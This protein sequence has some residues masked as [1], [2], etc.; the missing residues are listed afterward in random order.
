MDQ[1][2]SDAE[3]KMLLSGM[4]EENISVLDA[5]IENCSDCQARLERMIS[6]GNVVDGF[7]FKRT[8]NAPTDWTP[9]RQLRLTRNVRRQVGDAYSLTP[10]LPFSIGDFQFIKEIGRGGMGIVFRAHQI[11]LRR[12][13]A[14]KMIPRGL[15]VNQRLSSRLQ[16]EAEAAGRL[17]HPCIVKVFAIEQFD[18]QFALIMELVN[19]RNLADEVRDAK[20]SVEQAVELARR[21]GDAVRKAHDA[22]IIHRDLKPSNILVDETGLPKLTDFGLAQ[23]E[24]RPTTATVSGDI[25][26]TPSYM[27]PEQA[28][29]CRSEISETSDVYGLGATLYHLLTGRP[30]FLGSDPVQVL[31]QVVHEEPARPSR[32]HPGLYR[33]LETIVLKSLSKRPEDRYASVQEF[34]DDLDRFLDGRPIAARSVTALD[35]LRK[36]CRRHPAL[37]TLSSGSSVLLI[38]LMA[39]VIASADLSQRHSKTLQSISAELSDAT[40]EAA[41]ATGDVRRFESQAK[42]QTAAALR[43]IE[44]TLYDTQRSLQENPTEQRERLR[45][46]KGALAELDQVDQSLVDE[47]TPKRLRAQA[48][49]GIA[50]VTDFIGDDNGHSGSTASEKLYQEAITILREMSQQAPDDLKTKRDL[51]KALSQYGDGQAEAAHWA[52]AQRVWKEALPLHEELARMSPDAT[53]AMFDLAETHMFLGETYP[54]SEQGL[55]HLEKSTELIKQLA[56]KHPQ[57]R[58]IRL[59]QATI[60]R[61]VGDWYFLADRLDECDVAF[62]RFESIAEQIAKRHPLHLDSQMNHSTAFE[63]LGDLYTRRGESEKALDYYQ[64]ASQLVAKLGMAAPDNDDVQ[65]QVSFGYPPRGPDVWHRLFLG[66]HQG[67]R[68]P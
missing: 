43:V 17:N 16:A 3:L 39:V 6:E 40:V 66:D 46:L 35:H 60:H 23:Y 34:V 30:P 38:A 13:V 2:P 44:H 59:L 63:R 41:E 42:D 52:V 9:D 31:H 21:I 67:D 65:W 56:A 51:A 57:D 53:D 28:R 27:S 61:E 55:K 62:R 58:S 4:S 54:R 49:L 18:D 24:D 47:R 68:H 32:F 8:I 20:L 50:E 19:G 37:A 64:R 11:S 15:F 14:V 1:C 48:L 10:A 22:G 26:G 45:M 5:H 12:D 36:W 25:I 7:A 29:G 33:D